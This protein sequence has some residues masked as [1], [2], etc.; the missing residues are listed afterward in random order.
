L[1]KFNEDDSIAAL[2]QYVDSTYAGHYSKN[3]FQSTEFIIDCGHGR[4]FTVGNIIKYAQRIREQR[5]ATEQRK[6]IMKI[7]H[8]A[9]ILLYIHDTEN[10]H[11][12]S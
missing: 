7:L 10:N 9:L 12:S 6:D 1:Y 3:K 4:G 2:R 5:V 11:E 8:Y